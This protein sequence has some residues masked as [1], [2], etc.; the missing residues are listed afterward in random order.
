MF[1]AGLIAIRRLLCSATLL[2]LLICGAEVGLRIYEAVSGQVV[3]SPRDIVAGDPSHLAIPSWS[4]YQELKPL[5]SAVV[6][7]R[8]TQADV[9]VR[10]NSLGLRAAEPIVPKPRDVFRIIVV[11]DETIF[12]PETADEDHFCTLLGNHLQE[13]CSQK[14][15]VINA[16]IPGHCPL[17]EFVM[18]KQR[19]ISLQP[20]VVLMHFDW[21]DVADDRQIRRWARC[22]EEGSPQACPNARLVVS[23]K[24][25]QQYETW[26][27]H[28]RLLDRAMCGVSANWKKQVARQKAASRDSDTN[29]YAWLREERPEQNA[30]FRHAVSPVVDFSNLCH[31]LNCDFVVVTSPKPWQVSAKCSRGEGVRLAA[32]VARDAVYTNRAPFKVLNDVLSRAGVPFVDGSIVMGTGKEGESHFLRHAPR[33]SATG[34]HQM[35]ECVSS[36]LMRSIRGPWND[37]SV[38]RDRAVSGTRNSDIQWTGGQKSHA[39]PSLAPPSR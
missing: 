10:T 28:F 27:S 38:D 25:F 19:L 7:C 17:T 8:D 14:V 4:I 23:K 12:A 18:F 29:P 2:T 36:Y 24:K 16:G 37:P 39:V 26:R 6:E 9:Q 31:S 1:R 20:D 33:W 5:T 30:N 22:D 15:E 13:R 35:A 32:G 21:S 34:H 11:G 3:S